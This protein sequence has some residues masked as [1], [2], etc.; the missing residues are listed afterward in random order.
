[1]LAFFVEEEFD[2]GRCRDDAKFA[3]I[4]LA[5]FAQDFAQDVVADA[6]GGLDDAF[7]LAGRARFAQLVGERF[8]GA[9]AR[10]LEQAELRKAVDRGLDPVSGELLFELVDHRLAVL[11]AGHVDEI[12]HHDAAQIAQAQLPGDDL[13]GFQIGLENRLFKVSRSHKAAGVD[14]NGGQRLGLVDDQ[15]GA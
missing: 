8:A 6:A 9:L 15:V 10:H 12:D 4:E 2:D 7:A 5:G 1:M 3:G 13:R 14:V 11:R